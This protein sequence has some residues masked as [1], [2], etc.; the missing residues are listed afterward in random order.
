M[1]LYAIAGLVVGA[2]ALGFAR[3]DANEQRTTEAKSFSAAAAF[4]ILASL[5]ALIGS[6]A[7]YVYEEHKAA[8]ERQQRLQDAADMADPY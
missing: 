8:E 7:S 5:A 2:V 4:L 3:G 1:F 6:G